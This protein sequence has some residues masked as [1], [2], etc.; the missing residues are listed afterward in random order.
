MRL[1]FIILTFALALIGFA[2]TDAARKIAP[3]DKL[4]ITC[5]EEP[6]LSKTYSVTD[7]GK[8]LMDFVGVIEV[9][10]LTPAEAEKRI[11]EKLVTFSVVRTATVKVEFV[12]GSSPPV[13][14]KD[15]PPAANMIKV[16]GAIQN[17]ELIPFKSGMRVS[18]VIRASQPTVDADLTKIEVRSADGTK[19]GVDFSRFDPATNEQNPSLRAGDEV[20]FP[21]KSGAPTDPVKPPTDPVKPPTDPV[22]EA[23]P[24]FILGGVNRPG[25][26][27]FAPGMTLRKAIELA[28]GFSARGDAAR[29]R[30]ER[31]TDSPQVFDLTDPSK[32]AAI[33]PKD[34][35]VVEVVTQRRYLQVNGAV[36]S[37][38]LVEFH[39]GITLSQAIQNAGGLA[40][41]AK[42]KDVVIKRQGTAE[43]PET[44]KVNY[45]D[46]MKGYRG[47]TVL[48]PGD[49]VEIPGSKKGLNKTAQIAIGAAII[50]FL[51]GR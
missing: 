2:Q 33:K 29:V 9:Q 32:D 13:D 7:D 28:G 22:V 1:L 38:G 12:G 4:K 14:P 24:V 25:Q 34:Q 19:T 8:I 49:V 10:N 27:D 18:D 42:A 44:I 51:F 23:G 17:K 41:G 50:W 11:A 47:E 37:P 35:I 43:K 48:K 26:I 36:R 39:D 5:K 16:S 15:P 6:A 46:V 30:L 20:V 21:S 45:D 31:G 3:G 40:P